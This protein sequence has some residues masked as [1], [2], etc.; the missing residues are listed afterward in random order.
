MRETGVREM[1][2][3]TMMVEEAVDVGQWM[4]E[5]IM[6]G[7]MRAEL[8]ARREVTITT[9]APRTSQSSQPAQQ[10]GARTPAHARAADGVRGN[11]TP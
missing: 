3:G 11:L 1:A 10:P 4:A 9:R 8:R 5:E 6:V 2:G 7:L